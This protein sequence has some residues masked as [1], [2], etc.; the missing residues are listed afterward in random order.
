MLYHFESFSFLDLDS[1]D[2]PIKHT[3]TTTEV[4][5]LDRSVEHIVE[6]ALGLTEVDI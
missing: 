6:I 3:I 5:S 1:K 4:G 2:E